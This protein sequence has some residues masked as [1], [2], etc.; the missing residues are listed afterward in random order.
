MNLSATFKENKFEVKCRVCGHVGDAK[1]FVVE[2]DV[3]VTIEKI[4]ERKEVT[5]KCPNCSATE[6]LPLT[7][8]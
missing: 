6:T 4:V 7:I 8:W 1:D 2:T 3:W 5:I